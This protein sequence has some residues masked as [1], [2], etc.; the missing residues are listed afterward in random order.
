MSKGKS[1]SSTSSRAAMAIGIATM[2]LLGVGGVQAQN[3]YQVGGGSASGAYST[4]VGNNATANANS[5][6]AYGSG[7]NARGVSS[8]A[9]GNDAYAGGAQSTAIGFRSSDGGR[10]NVTSFGHGVGD[11]YYT[12]GA[13]SH[14]TDS[15]YST[16]ANVAR[17]TR[18]NDAVNVQQINPILSALGG[19]M[20]GTAGCDASTGA[21]TCGTVS[22]V[23]FDAASIGAGGIVGAVAQYASIPQAMTA[24]SDSV[25]NLGGA[26][27][28]NKT[29][30]TN[31]QGDVST[32]NTNIGAIQ[33]DITNI[34]GRVTNVE[35]S[36]NDLTTQINNG[37]VGMVKQ[38]AA[39]DNLTVGAATDGAA[40]DFTGTAGARKLVGVAEG[41]L[42]ADS[43]EA[44][45]GSQL[46]ATNERVTTAEGNITTIQGDV[47]TINTNIGAIQGD[48][49][50]IDGRVTN[51]EGSVSNLTTQINN[52][53]V[54][55]VKQ[56]AAG[57]NLTVG[58]ATDG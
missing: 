8:T 36:V 31:I 54:G 55:M 41:A 46:F 19:S 45:I 23:K 42:A 34:D 58:A 37:G 33:G 9:I 49:T 2:L 6:S 18:D 30:I 20:L 35:G 7:A 39:G 27:S 25:N 15:F 44:V 50:N 43:Q 4:A 47:S 40:V 32:I 52:G 14:Y 5:A 12:G 56:A 28:D 11:A 16:L 22:M 57:D 38:A 48:I 53:G 21:G 1:K 24:M 17:G 10:A 51:V 26:V 29:S 3:A 13:L